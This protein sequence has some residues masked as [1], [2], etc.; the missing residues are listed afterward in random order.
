MTFTRKNSHYL[1][2]KNNPKPK[3]L[4]DDFTAPQR[5]QLLM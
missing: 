5:G 1:I 3:G 2:N 4:N